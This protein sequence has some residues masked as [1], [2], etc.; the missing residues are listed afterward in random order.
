MRPR[1]IPRVVMG[2][3][4]ALLLLVSA[5]VACSSGDRQ[6]ADDRDGSER[7]GGAAA[8]EIVDANGRTL[9]LDEPAARILSLVPSATLTLR[10]LG[11]GDRL[12]GRTDYDTEPWASELPSV[13]GGLEPNL[14]AVVTLQPDL[15]VRFAGSQDRRTPQRLDDLGIPHLA[16][17]PDGIDDVLE[18]IRMLGLA[19][20]RTA[21]AD[22]LVSAIRSDL[23]DLEARVAAFPRK[24]VAYVL[25]GTPPWVAGPGTYIDELLTLAGGDNVFA[26][27]EALYAPV[28]PEE[29]RS[30]R[31][32]VVLA[33][34]AEA[35]DTSLAPDARVE[36]V[37]D[38]LEIP[39]PDLADSARRLAELLHGPLPS[40]P[41]PADP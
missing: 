31:I 29:V 40:G 10:T 13:G 23:Q 12:V 3:R 20:G 15:V 35:F 34:G 21:E 30:R 1:Q 9:R 5:G 32:D 22:S 18:T 25:G 4:H 27:L 37:D 7:A 39:G 14:E 6:P 38:R 16:V 19:T 33:S 8:V 36:V 24:S 17:R 11:A 28:S 2:L 41:L 26:D